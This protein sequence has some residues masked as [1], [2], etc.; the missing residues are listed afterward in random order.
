MTIGKEPR[1]PDDKPGTGTGLGSAGV[2]ILDNSAPWYTTGPF[3]AGVFIAVVIAVVL[4][5]S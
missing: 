3:I 1:Y 2:A 4:L 5:I